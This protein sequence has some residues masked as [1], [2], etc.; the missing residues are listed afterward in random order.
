VPRWTARSFSG[1]IGFAPALPPGSPPGDSSRGL[2]RWF[3]APVALPLAATGLA[4]LYA[5]RQPDGDGGAGA[6]IRRLPPGVRSSWCS[7]ISCVSF[8]P[9]GN[10][11]AAQPDVLRY[12]AGP[13]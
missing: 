2:R 11:D 10:G 5:P 1:G 9:G 4:N 8:R 3:P 12:S 6:G 13:A 7:T